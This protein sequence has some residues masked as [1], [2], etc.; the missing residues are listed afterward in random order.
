MSQM[1]RIM[2]VVGLALVVL[3]LVLNCQ[4]RAL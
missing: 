1:G 3:G 2:V 4:S